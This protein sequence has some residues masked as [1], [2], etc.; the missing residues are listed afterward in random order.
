M[1]FAELVQQAARAGLI[2]TLAGRGRAAPRPPAAGVLPRKPRPSRKRMHHRVAD[3]DKL[4]VEMREERRAR[5]AARTNGGHIGPNDVDGTGPDADIGP[6]VIHCNWNGTRCAVCGQTDEDKLMPFAVLP[7]RLFL[8][9]ICEACAHDE[10]GSPAKVAWRSVRTLTARP[11][12][13]GV[14]K[15]S[16]WFGDASPELDLEDVV[17]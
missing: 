14:V 15:D 4:L 1:T 13:S 17:E 3:A 6:P 8:G 2:G 9:T 10:G 11:R 5:I 12:L 16:D 7:I